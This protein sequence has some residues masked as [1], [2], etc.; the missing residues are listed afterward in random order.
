MAALVLAAG[1]SR[2][3][4]S[5]KLLTPLLGQPL[6]RHA[7]DNVLA[8]SVDE[9]LVVSGRDSDEVRAALHGLPLRSVFNPH[10][11]EGLS[12]SLHVGL[13]ELA[14]REA[15]VVVLGDQPTVFPSTIDTLIKAYFVSRQPIICPVYR[16]VRGH[17][18][19]F[20]REVFG[21]LM[22]V[23]GDE[24]G[25]SVIS[26]DASRVERVPL[27]LPPPRDVDTQDDYRFFLEAGL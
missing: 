17:P 1:A 14:H 20:S 2:R 10:Y 7:V 4:G 22:T 16:G 27:D 21:E 23:E 5:Q 15:V 6:V 18:V 19:L 12:T 25:R 11:E 9:V 24:G 3:F 13:N 8:S 26:R